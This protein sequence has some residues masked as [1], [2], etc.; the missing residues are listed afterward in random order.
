MKTAIVIGGGVAGC[1]TAYAL[2]DRGI[3]V[4]LIE[5][6]AKLATDASGNPVAALYPKLGLNQSLADNLTMQGFEYTQQLLKSMPNQD[7]WY[8]FCGQIQ[9]GFNVREQARQIELSQRYQ[10]QILNANEASKIAGIALKFGGLYFPQAGWLKPAVLCE[11]LCKHPNIHVLTS[12]EGLKLA[13][14]Q[15]GWRTTYANSQ[16]LEANMVV[17][18][19]ANEVKQFSQSKSVEITPVRG[20]LNTFAQTEASASMKTL[21]CSDH[22]LSP[23]INGQH[24]IGTS[25]AANDF[26]ASISEEDTRENLNALRAVSAE[27]YQTLDLTTVHGRVAWRSQTRDYIPLAGQLLDEEKL[28]AKPPRYNAKATD[29]PWLRG[30]YINAGHGSKGMT[31]A[32]LCAE[33]IARLASDEVLP[34]SIALASRLNP[35]RFLLR[36]LGLKQLANS[37]IDNL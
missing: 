23:A 13:Q 33:L 6:Q 9:L 7:H 34:V 31:T 12:T 5:R 1:S 29:L 4:T 22:Y 17:L 19:N 21:I 36:E 37:L 28:R 35:S 14:T 20:Q 24:I 16:E 25:Y 27:I 32:P 2:A 26:N 3:Q 30:L 18:C 11:N 15:A 8:D 10:L